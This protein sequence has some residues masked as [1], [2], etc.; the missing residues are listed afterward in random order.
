[1]EE[2]G[3]RFAALEQKC[4]Q[5]KMLIEKTNTV[6]TVQQDKISSL[7]QWQQQKL[8]TLLQGRGNASSGS[9]GGYDDSASLR[10]ES[11]GENRRNYEEP[12]PPPPVSLLASSGTV[13][14]PPRSPGA[15]GTL[16]ELSS[17]K[18][19][20]DS[21]DMHQN[22]TSD[23]NGDENE[24]EGAS[25]GDDGPSRARVPL[26]SSLPLS[27]GKGS[28]SP[29]SP[30]VRPQIH[31]IYSNARAPPL[32]LSRASVPSSSAGPGRYARDAADDTGGDHV[33]VEDDGEDADSTVFG[34][35]EDDEQG[36]CGD[37]DGNGEEYGDGEGDGD[38]DGLDDR[39]RGVSA[40][41]SPATSVGSH[42]WS[43]QEDEV[44]VDGSTGSGSFS[45]I[46]QYYDD[47]NL[48]EVDG[49]TV[50]SS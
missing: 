9:R 19:T 43:L 34:M 21:I 37:F 3:S 30:L 42:P 41:S 2:L 15:T 17:P 38:G 11:N 36:D 10:V 40:G 50:G 22:A 16:Q 48:D 1:M 46:Q 7:E 28:R 12:P 49:S 24:Q 44:S 33:E 39:G 18:L 35:L 8:Q 26:A 23:Q 13:G 31:N 32:G 29:R 25:A 14:K 4:K 47:H 5:L 20:S 45:M 27:P 6:I